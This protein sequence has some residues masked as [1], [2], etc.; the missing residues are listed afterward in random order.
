M[1]A[2][3]SAEGRTNQSLFLT[4][5][6]CSSV[7][8][9]CGKRCG[10]GALLRE[11]LDVSARPCNR[12]LVPFRNLEPLIGAFDAVAIPLEARDTDWIL[13]SLSG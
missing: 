5:F 3:T 4:M 6:T 12:G 8:V 13:A 9:F 2:L 10:A 11:A 7:N 1:I